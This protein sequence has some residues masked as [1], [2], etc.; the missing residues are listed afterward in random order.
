V[1]KAKK[2]FPSFFIV[3]S[4]GKQGDPT[5]KFPHYMVRVDIISLMVK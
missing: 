3:I 1:N 5:H 2:L 4:V